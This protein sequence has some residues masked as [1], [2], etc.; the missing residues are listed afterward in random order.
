[1]TTREK[2]P[3]Q[4]SRGTLKDAAEESKHQDN[5]GVPPVS[6]AEAHKV[7]RRWLGRE[8]DTD[9]LNAVLAAAA[10]EQLDGDPLWLLVI[11][12]AGNAKTETVQ[13]LGGIGAHVVSTISS[14]AGLLSATPKKD[15]AKDATGG[16]LR[17]IGDRGVLVIKD[18]TSILS[19]SG[20][21]RGCP[22][23]SP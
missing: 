21:R 7:F 6:L 11:S 15:V 2:G 20:D 23:G 19:M 1:M 17:K 16:L 8:Y 18:V 12:G 5:S 13:A 10:V 22:R 14:E 3:G 9:A 4:A